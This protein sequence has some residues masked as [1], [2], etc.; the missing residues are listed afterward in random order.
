[1]TQSQ[2]ESA[3]VE[4]G[5]KG[6]SKEGEKDKKKG[7]ELERAKRPDVGETD[8]LAQPKGTRGQQRHQRRGQTNE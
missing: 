5:G 6:K 8:G 4:G 3:V 7:I 2:V 1:M